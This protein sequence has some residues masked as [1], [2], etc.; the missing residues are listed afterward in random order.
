V[1]RTVAIF[2]RELRIYDNPL[3]QAQKFDPQAEYI[4]RYVP[5]LQHASAEQLGD[6]EN[7]HRLCPD[8]PS[9]LVTPD[10][11][12]QTVFAGC[13]AVLRRAWAGESPL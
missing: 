5:E 4:H 11:G 6:L 12:A 2:R 7:L 10:E 1:V 3:L 8:Y 9:P 13:P